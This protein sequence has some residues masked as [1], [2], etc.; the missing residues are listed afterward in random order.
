MCT[1]LNYTFDCMV[2]IAQQENVENLLLHITMTICQ[3]S[4]I[5]YSVFTLLAIETAENILT[6][7][8]PVSS[9]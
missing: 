2:S 8:N 4:K 3:S 5:H 6:L 9:L 7:L 1:Q